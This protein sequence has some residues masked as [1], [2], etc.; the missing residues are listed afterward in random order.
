MHIM[1]M[2]AAPE[3]QVPAVRRPGAPIDHAH[4]SR[5]TFGNRALEIEVLQL[6][7]DQAPQ[8]LDQLRKAVTEKSWRDAAHTLKG[9]AKAV[10]A[11][12]VAERAERAE[13][14]RAT[15]DPLVRERAVVA[16]EEALEEARSHILQLQA[17]V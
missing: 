7:A 15:P 12:R 6:F 14:L 4:L 9:S 2:S 16:I 11:I 13:A 1:Q 8:Y 5:Y 3:A 10:G 17:S